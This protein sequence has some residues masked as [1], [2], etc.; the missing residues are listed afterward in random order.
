[1][2][3][4]KK[5]FVFPQKTREKENY[6]VISDWFRKYKIQFCSSVDKGR[7]MEDPSA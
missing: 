2:V 1:M 7:A 4:V 3:I 5:K 6:F